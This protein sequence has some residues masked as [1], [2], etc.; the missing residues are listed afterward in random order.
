LVLERVP[1]R[2]SAGLYPKDVGIHVT[3]VD[4]IDD[5]IATGLKNGPKKQYT[6]ESAYF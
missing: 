2:I 5:M 4:S 3:I 6:R 1:E